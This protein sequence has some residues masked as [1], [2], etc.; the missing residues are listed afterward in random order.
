MMLDAV[1]GLGT[2]SVALWWGDTRF[3]RAI[4]ADL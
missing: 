4:H 1:L 3:K 2:V